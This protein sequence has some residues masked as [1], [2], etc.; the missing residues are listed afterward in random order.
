MQNTSSGSS[1]P[2]NCSYDYCGSNY[3]CTGDNSYNESGYTY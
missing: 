1:C 3:G 2:Y